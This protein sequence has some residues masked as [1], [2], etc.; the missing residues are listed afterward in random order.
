MQIILNAQEMAATIA[1]SRVQIPVKQQQVTT[2]KTDGPLEG[3]WIEL[4]VTSRRSPTGRDDWGD[5][6]TV[7][8]FVKR[9]SLTRPEQRHGRYLGESEV[10]GQPAFVVGVIAG[11]DPTVFS[12]LECFSS[13]DEMKSAWILD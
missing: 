3:I 2:G 9:A 7:G 12:S 8:V 11:R 6:G 10:A 5:L 13:I 4:G 1:A